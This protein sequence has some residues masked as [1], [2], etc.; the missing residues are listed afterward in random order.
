MVVIAEAFLQVL[1]RRA[2]HD[3]LNVQPPIDL[4]TLYRYVGDS[5]ARFPNIDQA[6]R[7]KEISVCEHAHVLGCVHA[8]SRNF[9]LIQYQTRAVFLFHLILNRKK[10][11]QFFP[12]ENYASKLLPEVKEISYF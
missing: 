1:E 6:E 7:F 8:C 3:G 4:K 5:H 11:T 12:C 10:G 9:T 2:F